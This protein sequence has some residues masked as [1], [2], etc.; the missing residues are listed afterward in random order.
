MTCL[1]SSGKS[2]F[3]QC[4]ECSPGTNILLVPRSQPWTNTSQHQPVV[5]FSGTERARASERGHYT[6]SVGFR[7]FPSPLCASLC[8]GQTLWAAH[9]AAQ[10][11]PRGPALG[12]TG[13]SSAVVPEDFLP[14]YQQQSEKEIAEEWLLQGQFTK[15][16]WEAGV[17]KQNWTTVINFRMNNLS[18]KAFVYASMASSLFCLPCQPQGCTPTLSSSESSVSGWFPS[19]L[20]SAWERSAEPALLPSAFFFLP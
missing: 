10:W 5:H 2:S 7:L 19:E 20:S 4:L 12:S 3:S 18:L 16:W 8:P 15:F 1:L 17:R 6:I 14:L 9:S 13:D 11:T